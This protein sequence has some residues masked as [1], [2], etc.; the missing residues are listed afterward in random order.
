MDIYI[1]SRG[2]QR[3]TFGKLSFHKN[4]RQNKNLL[5]IN[6][7]K[8][9]LY[10]KVLHEVCEKF[11]GAEEFINQKIEEICYQKKLSVEEV[12]YFFYERLRFVVSF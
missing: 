9:N 4:S 5:R 3:A 10:K 12:T 6:K 7:T 1:Y 8:L 2:F 11:D